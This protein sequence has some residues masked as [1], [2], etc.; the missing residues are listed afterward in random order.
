M[1]CLYDLIRRLNERN[2]WKMI[3]NDVVTRAKRTK[4]C[5]VTRGISHADVEN[6]F[7]LLNLKKN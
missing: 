7:F 6:L 3:K 2:E 5:F 4:K 1:D